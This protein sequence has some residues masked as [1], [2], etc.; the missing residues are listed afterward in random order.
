MARVGELSLSMR[1]SACCAVAWSLVPRPGV[2]LA[3]Q[4]RGSCVPPL[5]GHGNR[6]LVECITSMRSEHGSILEE[7][8]TSK[9]RAM[10]GTGCRC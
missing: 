10:R 2:L 6:Q 1:A 3:G 5:L 4:E 9:R 7:Q 8:R